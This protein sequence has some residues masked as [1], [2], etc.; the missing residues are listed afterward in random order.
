MIKI[1]NKKYINIIFPFL[2]AL[3][4][5]LI[6][7]WYITYINLWLDNFSLNW[8]NSWIKAFLLALPISYLVIPS[9]R[10][11]LEKISY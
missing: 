5:S 7:S 1:I 3:M 8:F 9:V 6:M 2:V 10:K 4:M 11:F